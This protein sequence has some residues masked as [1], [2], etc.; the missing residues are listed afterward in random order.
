M[1]RARGAAIRAVGG[2]RPRRSS[3]WI[4]GAG[5]GASSSRSPRRR[6]SRPSR[7]PPRRRPSRSDPR[8]AGS[9]PAHRPWPPP[10]RRR[11][12][13]SS[14]RGPRPRCRRPRPRGRRQRR[15]RALVRT[16]SLVD[17]GPQVTDRPPGT[18]PNRGACQDDRARR[19]DDDHRAGDVRP[20]RSTSERATEPGDRGGPGDGAAEID[21]AP[22]EPSDRIGQRDPR[23]FDGGEVERRHA[24]LGERADDL[25]ALDLGE[26]E[27]RQADLLDGELR[28]LM[29]SSVRVSV[30]R[31]D[32]PDTRV[33]DRRP[34]YSSPLRYPKPPS[35]PGPAPAS[36][37]LR[38]MADVSMPR[39]LAR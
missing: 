20:A 15:S 23:A 9:R 32:T 7:R 8:R 21:R 16:G 28:H 39:P 38:T 26:M 25:V 19:P 5:L 3:P 13:G 4:D 37:G 34:R 2:A 33:G 14:S 11:A 24:N 1:Y 29:S 27:L 18:L 35:T 12:T 17:P 10:R 22:V 6:S 31:K 30:D 36:G